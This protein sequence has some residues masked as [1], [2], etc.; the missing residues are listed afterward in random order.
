MAG[1]AKICVTCGW[2]AWR[3][4]KA[5][6]IQ[7]GGKMQAEPL[8]PK[9]G[10]MPCAVCSTVFTPANARIKT[11]R[12]ECSAELTRINSCEASRRRAAKIKAG[13]YAPKV[14]PWAWLRQNVDGEGKRTILHV[15]DEQM[16]AGAF[17]WPDAL[18]VREC[19][20]DGMAF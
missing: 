8:V 18:E 14:I 1:R 15:L 9:P 12:P 19:I 7:C 17:P 6:C 20:C 11:C 13:T 5:P 3:P 10:P 2:R 16:E 4:A